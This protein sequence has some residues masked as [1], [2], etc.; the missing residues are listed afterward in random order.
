MEKIKA[1]TGI[2]I[3]LAIITMLC[4]T[5]AFAQ[6]GAKLSDAKI[7]SAA[8][9]ANQSDIDFANMATGERKVVARDQPSPIFFKKSN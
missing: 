6:Q 5:E 4:T 9:V 2:S 3:A 7:A 1:F 8:V